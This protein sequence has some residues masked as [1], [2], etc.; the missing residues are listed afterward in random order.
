MV[1]LEDVA[2][3]AGVTPSSVSYALAG[4]GTLSAATRARILKCAQELGYRPNLVARGLA[5]GKTHT[6]GM[7]V[8]DIANP[9]YGVAAQAVERTAYRRGYRVFLVDSDRNEQL[10]QDLLADLVARSVDGILAMP[11]GI[12][13]P[14]VRAA[15]AQGMPVVWCLWEDDDPALTPAVDLDY[16]T[17]GRLVAR[18]LVT[19]GHRRVA[20]L[21][22]GHK[23]GATIHEHRLRVAGCRD[24]LA[25]AGCPLDPDLLLFGDSTLESG[26]AAGRALLAHPSPPSAV[27]A[28]NDLMALGLLAAAQE[29]GIVVPDALSI[30][31][32]DDILATAYAGPPLTT[33]HVDIAGV[34]TEATTLLLEL[35]QGQE[36]VTPPASVPTLVARRSTG[37]PPR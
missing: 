21:T 3:A 16:Y 8:A 32:F 22:H 13:A 35:I 30:V 17:G 31:G 25:A 6:M 12:P 36:I 37:P 29:A 18:H 2:R 19:L 26:I 4:K 33:V 11:G 20:I 14:M 34:M 23:P 27:F 10:G 9:F 7:I 24:G 28:T 15:H 5:A 1:T